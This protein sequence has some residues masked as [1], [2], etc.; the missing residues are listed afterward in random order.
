MSTPSTLTKEHKMLAALSHFS[1]LLFG[2]GMVMPAIFWSNH[3][4]N[5]PYVRF[6]ALQALAFQISQPVG[7]TLL[8]LVGMIIFLIL[9]VTGA[10]FVS[11]TPTS[12][13][14]LIIGGLIALG[15]TILGSMT[16]LVLALIGG[17]ACLLGTEFEYPWLG[18]WIHRR[19][20]EA[21]NVA[22]DQEGLSSPNPAI[23]DAESELIQALCHFAAL[24]PLSG[25]FVPLAIWISHLSAGT[26][27]WFQAIQAAAFQ[28]LQALASYGLVGAAYIFFVVAMIPITS[29]MDQ[30]TG[31]GSSDAGFLVI[32]FSLLLL[33]VMIFISMLVMAGFQTLALVAGLKDPETPGL[34]VPD[35]REMVG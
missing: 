17:V 10:I 2:L 7:L 8:A 5:S 21:R 35:P 14:L 28:S 3:R 23:E 13:M 15:L 19:T 30:G 18:G 20:A 34:S 27:L 16:Y 1:I 33:L 26:K 9:S 29:L 32:G 6:Q 4:K 25:I 24:N 22:P 12:R 31:L 11:D